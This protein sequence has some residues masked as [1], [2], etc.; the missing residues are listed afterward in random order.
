VTQPA[1]AASRRETLLGW[2]APVGGGLAGALAF[3]PFG[4]A[5]LIPFFPLGMFIGM[6]LAPTPRGAFLRALAGGFT[7]YMIAIS[8]LLT[9]GRFFPIVVGGIV[10]AALYLTLFPAVSA[11]ALR[12]WFAPLPLMA[13]FAAFAALWVLAEWLR[14]LGELAVPMVQ[15]G[16]AWA[17]WPGAVQLAEFLGEAGLN[18]QVLL[19]SGALLSVLWLAGVFAPASPMC[20]AAWAASRELRSPRA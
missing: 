6:R 9:L 20:P 11:W 2:F 10:I 16:H 7:Y 12:R 8:W 4:V 18:A 17:R 1:P 13:H 3:D 19:L 14:T 5:F 15:V